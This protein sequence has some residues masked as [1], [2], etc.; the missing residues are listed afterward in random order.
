MRE[1]ERERRKEEEETGIGVNE[2]GS[3]KGERMRE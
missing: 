3:K 1:L 2:G